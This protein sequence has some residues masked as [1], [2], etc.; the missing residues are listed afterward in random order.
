MHGYR[1]LTWSAVG[2]LQTPGSFFNFSKGWGSG[3]HS[4]CTKDHFATTCTNI[5]HCFPIR[6]LYV[7]KIDVGEAEPRTIVSGLVKYVPLE[8]MQVRRVGRVRS[9]V[10][11]GAAMQWTNTMQKETKPKPLKG[12]H[13]LECSVGGN[14]G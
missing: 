12:M 14:A 9:S 11:K 13:I 5:P 1:G 6:S 8:Q 7:E 10:L 4:S 3:W 2:L